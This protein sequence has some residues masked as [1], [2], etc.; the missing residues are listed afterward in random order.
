[1]QHG[2]ASS[3]RPR[4]LL[5]HQQIIIPSINKTACNRAGTDATN[6]TA[7]PGRRAS[8]YAERASLHPN[9]TTAYGRENLHMTSINHRQL[10]YTSA[11][12]NTPST[13][14]LVQLPFTVPMSLS[15]AFGQYAPIEKWCSE[16]AEMAKKPTVL[17][18]ALI[19]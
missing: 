10:H 6:L 12:S 11:Q 15:R 14:L 8:Y 16:L 1:V 19:V 5:G 13:A 7:R 18:K 2:T 4:P 17:F 3:H 9:Q